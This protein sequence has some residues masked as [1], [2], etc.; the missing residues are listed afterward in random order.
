MA[1]KLALIAYLTGDH[2]AWLQA[3]GEVL[4]GAGATLA[5]IAC[6]A[7][8]TWVLQPR[9]YYLH[10]HH[11]FMGL[12]LSPLA[13]CEPPWW[14]GVLLGVALGQ[15]VEGAARWSIA[16]LWNASHW[17]GASH[18]PAAPPPAPKAV[19]RSDSESGTFSQPG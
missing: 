5:A 9:G 17:H 8:A 1:T 14:S 12:A 4:W 6:I 10:L 18:A 15:F 2:F 3:R 16:P 11:W 7:A 19:V 13:V